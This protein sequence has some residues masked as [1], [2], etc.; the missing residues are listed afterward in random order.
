MLDAADSVGPQS[1]Q[2]PMYST[3]LAL[4]QSIQGA[5]AS[6]DEVVDTA[7]EF[8]NSGRVVLIGTFK[9]SRLER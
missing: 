7:I 6:E 2:P 9:G 4:V 8:V 5:N 1:D 3:L